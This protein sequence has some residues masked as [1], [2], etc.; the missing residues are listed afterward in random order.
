MTEETGSILFNQLDL[1]ASSN[2]LLCCRSISVMLWLSLKKDGIFV[3][4]SVPVISLRRAFG[5]KA[6]L[7]MWIPPR[8]YLGQERA[9]NGMCKTQF[10]QS[11]ARLVLKVVKAPQLT[12]SLLHLLHDEPPSARLSSH[13]PMCR[14]QASLWRRIACDEVFRKIQHTY[15]VRS[16]LNRKV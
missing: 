7:V 6:G 1:L 10:L 15:G 11:F 8:M 16:P 13:L 14:C 3:L 5:R 12:C 9:V 2:I 4:Y